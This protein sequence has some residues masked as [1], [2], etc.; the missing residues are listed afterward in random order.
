MQVNQ[1]V[2]AHG[3]LHA[4]SSQRGGSRSGQLLVH[5]L[6]KESTTGQHCDFMNANKPLVSFSR[7][8]GPDCRQ[9]EYQ[10][11]TDADIILVILLLE[12]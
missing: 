10:L 8:L 5:N 4:C 3:I 11:P 2:F 6:D 12:L 1:C 7:M 9:R